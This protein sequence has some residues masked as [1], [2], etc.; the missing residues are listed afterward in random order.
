ME[1]NGSVIPSVTASIKNEVLPAAVTSPQVF[2]AKAMFTRARVISI[3]G[4]SDLG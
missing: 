2:P 3:E 4:V 1:V